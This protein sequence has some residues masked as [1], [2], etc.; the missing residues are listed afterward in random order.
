MRS[1]LSQARVFAASV[2][3]VAHPNTCLLIG[4]GLQTDV[5]YDWREPVQSRIHRAPAGDETVP[6][7]SAQFRAVTPHTRDAFPVTHAECF[8]NPEFRV[9]TEERV[10]L[11]LASMS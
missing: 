6:R 11:V 8:Q 5:A 1:R 2:A 7:A 3:G 10:R 4:D 9:A